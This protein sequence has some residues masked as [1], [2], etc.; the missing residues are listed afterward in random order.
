LRK[1]M[2]CSSQMQRRLSSK[3][4]FLSCLHN[5]LNSELAWTLRSWN[6]SR[7]P[8]TQEKKKKKKI[9]P[10]VTRPATE[11]KPGPYRRWKANL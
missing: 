10:P 3:I 9:W 8:C 2:I 6:N 4:F 11:L 1:K 7:A 5:W